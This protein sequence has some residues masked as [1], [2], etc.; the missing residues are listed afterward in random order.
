MRHDREPELAIYLKRLQGLYP[1]GDPIV[2][3]FKKE[4]SECKKGMF[5][6]S[7]YLRAVKTRGK[8]E[9]AGVNLAPLQRVIAE[10]GLRVELEAI[11]HR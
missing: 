2:R 9:Q 8:L 1:K 3:R 7:W 5:E 6:E 4:V 10:H 11:K